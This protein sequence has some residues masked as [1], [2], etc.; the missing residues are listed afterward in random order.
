VKVAMDDD[1]MV[2]VEALS[3]EKRAQILQG[4]AT[5]FASDGYEGASMSRIA[6]A[7][8]VSKGT[9]YNHFE[10]KAHLFAAFIEQTCNQFLN[11]IFA[12]ITDDDGLESGLSDIGRRIIAMMGSPKGEII[13]RVLAA[14]AIKFPELAKI[15]YEAGPARATGQ[16]AAWLQ[17][18]ANL[19]RLVVP[20]AQLAA[21][22]FFALCQT[23]IGLQIRL[24]L[25]PY[26]TAAE[27]EQLIESA[28]RM[29]LR[30][31]AP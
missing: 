13:Q 26:P 9:L 4:A 30:T 24:H 1:I 25:R 5:I 12:G 23:R 3:P 31:Y 10:S 28:V 27:I 21:E 15:F 16:M 8:S 6:A 29:F 11:E 19:G 14:E 18:Q 2:D 20:D 17:R 22:Q 7:A